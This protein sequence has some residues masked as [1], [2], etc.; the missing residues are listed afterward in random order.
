MDYDDRGYKSDFKKEEDEK[1]VEN[2]Q[3]FIMRLPVL[4][5]VSKIKVEKKTNNIFLI[6]KKTNKKD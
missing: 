1:I 4:N 2:S 5:H 6:I 3:D